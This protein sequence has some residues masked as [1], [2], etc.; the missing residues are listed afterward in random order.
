[1]TAIPSPFVAQLAHELSP[2]SI[3]NVFGQMMVLQHPFDLQV[4]QAG[5][6]LIVS[7]LLKPFPFS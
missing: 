1:V 6:L 5:S 4:F 2:T 3:L 7:F